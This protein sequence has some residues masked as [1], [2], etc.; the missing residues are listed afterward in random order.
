MELPE[1]S[2]ARDPQGRRD[3]A[4]RRRKQRTRKQQLGMAPHTRREEWRK[5]A[6]DS[7]HRGGRVDI[8]AL[9]AE[10]RRAYPPIALP[11]W[12]KSS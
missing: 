11:Q 8:V 5:G 4:L 7:Y 3:R 9:L 6:Q 12:L 10:W 2:E 1:T